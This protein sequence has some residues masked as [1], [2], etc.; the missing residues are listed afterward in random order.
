MWST[1]PNVARGGS[2]EYAHAASIAQGNSWMQ[3]YLSQSKYCAVDSALYQNGAGCGKCYEISYLGVG[4]TDPGRAGT[5]RIQVVDSGSAKEFDCV[6]GAFETIT[7]TNTGIF[8]ITYTEIPCESTPVTAVIL[9]GNNAWYV[10][11]LFAGGTTSVSAASITVGSNQWSMDRV[12]GATWKA[13]L[14]GTTN[15]SVSFRI[16][17]SNGATET[18]TGCFGGSW[19]VATSS[20]CQ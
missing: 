3:P 18:L 11:V 15:Q 19:P 10:K 14:D 1:D 16:Q 4:G 20:Q 6:L 17:Y 2:C 12:S 13:N 5:E 8:P 9:D 7:G